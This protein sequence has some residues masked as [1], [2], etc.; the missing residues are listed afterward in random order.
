MRPCRRPLSPEA[1]SGAMPG[2]LPGSAA[3]ATPDVWCFLAT[4]GF[5]RALEVL[6]RGLSRQIARMSS[7]RQLTWHALVRL[8]HSISPLILHISIVPA[9]LNKPG[10]TLHLSGSTLDDAGIL[11]GALGTTSSGSP[12]RSAECLR[13][14]RLAR[15]WPGHSRIRNIFCVRFM[16]GKRI[17]G[18]RDVNLP[19]V[20]GHTRLSLETRRL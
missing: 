1:F 2:W 11:G 4:F 8:G 14:L 9:S 3:V 17:P 12:E 10:K 7:S 16:L 18:Q 6:E 20:C 5:V 13:F 19:I 15:R